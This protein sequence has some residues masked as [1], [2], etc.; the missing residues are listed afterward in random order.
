MKQ[1]VVTPLASLRMTLPLLLG[2]A[3]LLLMFSAPPH[4]IDLL[5][6]GVLAVL[7]SLWW[8]PAFGPLFIG[9]ALP[10]YFYGRPLAGPLAVSPP[11]FVLLLAWPIA[12]LKCQKQLRLPR[13]PYDLPLA[14]F[15]VASLLALAVSEYP[16]LSARELRALVLEPV[17]FFWL[18]AAWPGASRL[19]LGGFLASATLAA[20][21]AIVQVVLGFGGTEAEGV[22]RAQ[23]WYPSPN[24]LALMLGRAWPFLLALGL[25]RSRAALLPAATV[26]LAMLLTFSSGGW[27]GAAAGGTLAIAALGRRRLAAVLAAASVATTLGVMGLAIAGA[28]GLVIGSLLPER[29][30][31]LR[32]AG[33][34]RVDLWLSSLAMLRDH[35]LFGVGLDNFTYLY[36]QVYI[37]EGGIA[38]P[39]LSHPHN[40]LLHWWLEMGLL[41]LVA[42]VWLVVRFWQLAAKQRG[43][44]VAGAM[45]AMAD[46]LVHG[47]IDQSYFL[48]DLAFVFWLVL[49]L[50]I[51]NAGSIPHSEQTARSVASGDT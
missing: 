7:A 51:D 48:V 17:L 37:R 21:V 15:L 5:A 27:L 19:A 41:G 44:L 20:S 50:A 3:G 43:W 32:Q 14:V 46:T 45:G 30:N 25:A 18:L 13:T 47:L 2:A 11:G 23:A 6:F 42:F 28:N 34:I 22:R 29:L 16:L 24:H 35:P 12:L 33:G 36:Q 26:G 9:A 49:A 1:V 10:F 8:Q 39:N 38:E 4:R 31:P 40:W